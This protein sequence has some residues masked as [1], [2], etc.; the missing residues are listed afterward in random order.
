MKINVFTLFPEVFQ[1]Y[2]ETSILKRAIQNQ[3]VKVYLNNI[4]NWTVDKHHVTDDQPY[5]GGGGM[6]MKPE[7][8]FTAVERVLGDGFEYPIILLTPQGRLFD[9]SVAYELSEQRELALLCGRYEGVD[10]RVRQHLVTDEIS[11]GDYVLSGGELPAM[12]IIDSIV[13]LLPG[14]LGDPTGAQ[15]DSHSSGLLEYPHYTRPADFR[16]WEVPEVLSSGDH[17]RIDRWRREQ[18][19]LRTFQR[20]PDLLEMAELSDEDQ[21]FLDSLEQDDLSEPSKAEK[22]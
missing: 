7:P 2:L 21:E 14:A 12:V 20:R 13:R 4:R 17:A 5:G 10:E 8:I 6:V 18:A 1:T 9:Q 11:I 22:E 16:G 15:E 19:L 3:L